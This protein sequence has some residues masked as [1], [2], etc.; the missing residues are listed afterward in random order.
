MTALNDLNALQASIAESAANGHH[1]CREI[2]HA[3][4][5]TARPPARLLRS[6]AY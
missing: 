3:Q 5:S 4:S 6:F 2:V 1:L